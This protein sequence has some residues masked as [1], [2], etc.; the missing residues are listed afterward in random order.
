MHFSLAEFCDIWDPIIVPQPGLKPILPAVKA[1]FLNHWT[2]K[3]VPI[4]YCT[5]ETS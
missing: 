5:F 4:L 2:G 3:E 1:Q